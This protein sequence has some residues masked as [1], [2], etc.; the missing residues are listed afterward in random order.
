MVTL[1]HC[2]WT[3]R[4]FGSG[5]S[6]ERWLAQYALIG[7]NI[8]D[9]D[10]VF[11]R[12][13][14]N[15][16][17]LGAFIMERPP[18]GNWESKTIQIPDFSTKVQQLTVGDWKVVFGWLFSM[19]W[20]ATHLQLNQSPFIEITLEQ[21]CPVGNI[22]SNVVSVFEAVLTIALRAHAR[23]EQISVSS[24]REREEYRVLGPRVEVP[25]ESGREPHEFDFLFHLKD[26][27]GG[28]T[29][30]ERMRQI[31]SQN[32]EFTATFL[33]Y[34]RAP[35]RYV[36]DRLRGSVL[37]LAHLTSAFP[38]VSQR[39]REW[40]AALENAPAEVRVFLPS[41]GL[42]AVPEL[43]RE[44]LTPSICEALGLSSK[45][46]FIESLGPAFRWAMLREG[47]GASGRE[48]LRLNHQLRALLHL[49]LLRLLGFEHEEAERR[50][51]HSIK[52]RGVLS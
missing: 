49:S 47:T 32:P 29:F 51:V 16:R 50:M 41:A 12:V 24:S 6:W 43:A 18:L 8:I 28:Y 27:A 34:E 1:F 42:V 30:V 26:M 37:A 7:N 10:A 36:E 35:P 48:L 5:G 3:K 46:A 52:Q 22:L 2:M 4:Q 19:R 40:L 9:P 25:I 31:I 21:P 39:P 13:R 14:I 45:E 17:G 20:G 38:G 44:L 33:G 11:D 15:L 23:V